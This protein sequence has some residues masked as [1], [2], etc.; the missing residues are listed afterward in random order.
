MYPAA[1]YVPDRGYLFGMKW[2]VV[3]VITSLKLSTRDRNRVDIY[4]DGE[5]DLVIM[6]SIAMELSVGQE[7]SNDQI[8]ELK[9]RDLEEEI[10]L[11]A[12]RLIN[13]RP[14]SERELRDRFQQK[15][16]QPEI[17]DA[18]IARLRG[19]GLVDDQAFAHAWVE[20]RLA[21]RPRSAWALKY[22]LR[23]KGVPEDAIQIALEDFD[24][25]D[26]AYRAASKAARKMV[27]LPWEQFNRRIAAYLRRR[28]FRY[29]TISPIVRRVW[30][31]TAGINGESE[32]QK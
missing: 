27:E 4:L 14:R 11:Q 10:Y 2:K 32:D 28:G 21:F 31:E 30:S 26:A 17:Q 13:R 20:N 12:I 9:K 16:A 23:K 25:E 6:K 1:I 29:S 22:E 7:L 15:R 24:E 5:K 19:K 3:S 8:Q 18:A